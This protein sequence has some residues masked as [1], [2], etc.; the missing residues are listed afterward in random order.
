MKG[1]CDLKVGCHIHGHVGV[2]IAIV[3][4]WIMCLALR[5]D[6]I[7]T[8]EHSSLPPHYAHPV[9]RPLQDFEAPCVSLETAN[10]QSPHRVTLRRK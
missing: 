5:G 3:V 2:V 9:V 10:Q 7:V 6:T 1:S 4:G 8:L